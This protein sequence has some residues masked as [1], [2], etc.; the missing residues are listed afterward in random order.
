MNTRLPMCLLFAALAAA[1]ACG[2][3][4]ADAATFTARGDS[5]KAAG[6][7]DLAIEQYD[8]A[9]ARDST[10]GRAFN[11]RGN[12]YRERGD[13]DRAIRDFDRAIKLDAKHFQAIRNR[14]R[15]EFYVARFADAAADF[16]RALQAD[17]TS[18]A[19]AYNL[20]W[21]HIA[22]RRLGQDDTR[23]FAV[24]FAKTD[25]VAWPAPAGK[26]L[27]GQLTV[28]QFE[29]AAAQVDPRVKQ[30]QRCAAAFYRGEEALMLKKA[31]EAA[32][33]FERARSICPEQWTE[34]Q[35]SVAELGR[36]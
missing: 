6:R 1:G 20:L 17:S 9:I 26:Y 10:D 3:R 21:L 35:A 12:A 23:Q 30:D 7:L 15:T 31:T 29:A 2:K 22:R 24:Q 27:L 4:A 13:Y 34:Y 32:T 19:A 33:H 36:L 18:V 16:E 5:L 28:E 25:Q 8:R 14:A 11:N